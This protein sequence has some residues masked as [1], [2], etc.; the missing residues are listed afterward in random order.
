MAWFDT[1]NSDTRQH[2]YDEITYEAYK[3]YP[4]AGGSWT[5]IVYTINERYIGMTEAGAIAD[6]A[7]L[8]GANPSWTVSAVPEN[9]GG[10]WSIRIV[11]QVIGAWTED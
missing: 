6:A 9:N 5:Q 1:Y 11:R 8:A 2:V 10:G 3:Y 7:T 4:L